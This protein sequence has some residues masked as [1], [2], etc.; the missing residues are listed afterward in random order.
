MAGLMIYHYKYS[1]KG[2]KLSSCFINMIC[3]VLMALPEGLGRV[4]MRRHF[5]SFISPVCSY[6]FFKFIYC[7]IKTELTTGFSGSYLKVL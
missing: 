5:A 7:G 1:T 3:T 6:V 2:F 4:G